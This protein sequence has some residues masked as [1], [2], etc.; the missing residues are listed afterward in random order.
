MAAIGRRAA[1]IAFVAFSLAQA[2]ADRA[3]DVRSQLE[4]VAAALTAGNPAEAMT[5]FDKSCANY[6]EI[7][8]YFEGLTSAFQIANEI[9]VLDEQDSAAETKVTVNWTITLIDLGSNYTERRQ[10]EINVRLLL[11][12]Q[13]WKIAGFAPTAI[14]NPQQKSAPAKNP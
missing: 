13:K 3:A 7:S 14:F 1:A 6:T 10:G 5:V 2:R 8:N 9:D 12:D 11:K 4:A